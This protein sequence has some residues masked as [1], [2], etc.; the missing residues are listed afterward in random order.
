MTS[1]AS[2]FSQDDTSLVKNTYYCTDNCELSIIF[3]P[4]DADRTIGKN[5]NSTLSYTMLDGTSRAS[6]PI[7]WTRHQ[8][9][10]YENTYSMTNHSFTCNY[11]LALNGKEA[12]CTKTT[13]DPVNNSNIITTIFTSNEVLKVEGKTITYQE[14][15]TTEILVNKTEVTGSNT[16]VDNLRIYIDGAKYDG[17]DASSTTTLNLKKGTSHIL[18]VTGSMKNAND[19]VDIIPVVFGAALSKFALWNSTGILSVVYANTSGTTFPVNNS[20]QIL[21]GKQCWNAT[22]NSVIGCNSTMNSTWVKNWCEKYGFASD[23][24]GIDLRNSTSKMIPLQNF[25][26]A[27]Y[28]LNNACGSNCIDAWR[29]TNWT[30]SST[31]LNQ[32]IAFNATNVSRAKTWDTNTDEVLQ[33]EYEPS[34]VANGQLADLSGNGYSGTNTGAVYIQN[35]TCAKGSN[36]SA[37]GCY[38]FDTTTDKIDIGAAYTMPTGAW[39]VET[40]L[41][42][43]SDLTSGV[44]SI[45]FLKGATTQFAWYLFEN[46]IPGNEQID[47]GWR[48]SGAF[49]SVKGNWSDTLRGTW[50]HLVG[51]YDG[52]NPTGVSNYKLYINGVSIPVAEYDGI[53][54]S[55]TYSTIGSQNGGSSWIGYMDSFRIYNRTLSPAEVLG[56]YL[57]LNHNGNPSWNSTLPITGTTYFMNVTLISPA[58]NTLSTKASQTMYYN[59][60]S[61]DTVIACSLLINGSTNQTNST[62][63]SDVLSFFNISAFSDGSYLW[64]VNCTTNT[65]GSEVSANRT[66]IIDTVKPSCALVNRTPADINDTSTGL[67]NV[68]VNCTDANGINVT[69]TSGHFWA[70]ASRTVDGMM[71]PG[72]PNAWSIRPPYNNLTAI[73]SRF[74]AYPLF[75]AQGRNRGFWYESLGLNSTINNDTYSY[76]VDDGNY[77]YF[78]ITNTSSTTALINYTSIV[79]WTAFRQNAQLSYDSLVSEAKKNYSFTSTN[80]LLVKRY[81]LERIRGSVNYTVVVFADLGFTTLSPRL[82]RNYYCNSTY[83]VSGSARPVVSPN[84]ALVNTFTEAQI[85]NKSFLDRNSSYVRSTYSVTNG[86]LAGIVTTN[87]SYLYY[88]VSGPART[89]IMKYVNGPTVTNVSFAQTNSVWTSPDS[90]TT[91]TIAAWSADIIKTSVKKNDDE[92]QFGVYA[93]DL[94]GNCYFNATLFYDDITPTNHKISSPFIIA[95]NSS[96]APY[97]FTKNGIHSGVMGI[98]VNPAVDPDSVGNVTH[99]LTLR[100]TDGSWNYTIND[101]F[102]CPNDTAVW[103]YFNTSLVPMGDYRMNVSATS[104]DD[105]TDVRSYLTADNFTITCYTT[106]AGLCD[107]CR[108][109]ARNVS[110]TMS[111]SCV[112]VTGCT[113][114]VGDFLAESFNCSS[115]PLV[116]EIGHNRVN[117]SYHDPDLRN[118]TFDVWSKTNGGSWTDMT[119]IFALL[120]AAIIA[121]VSALLTGFVGFFVLCGMIVLLLSYELIAFS[122]PAAAL[123]LL[124]S[125]G[126]F[127]GL[128][129]RGEG[130]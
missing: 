2:A 126:L 42:M 24:T 85:T 128:F 108:Y 9:T 100:N 99:N 121:F 5:G 104:G 102:K 52:L 60:S 43:N 51:T 73:D 67:F 12:S 124:A 122:M 34:S 31:G 106:L 10:E 77:N 80:V 37:L 17:L 112:S 119:N 89:A 40:W 116:L 7:T 129:F 70:F 56:H 118:V 81:D 25:T 64:G 15:E 22:S 33:H 91:W 58:N 94:A 26:G 93:C 50:V 47:F 79:E 105:P 23:C 130:K 92:F 28:I 21:Y 107:G 41:R 74:P 19:A 82:V 44:R 18:K 8:W 109:Q 59:V 68:L 75:R 87:E 76:A 46:G 72:V 127:L 11:D 39:T 95:Y 32:M 114:Q 14:L 1:I 78:N 98:L 45:A 63:I 48:N 115:F 35:A 71:T 4:Q 38:E 84:C 16:K 61:N 83:N 86:L 66:I 97:D 125:I 57:Q 111:S 30:Q 101:S 96:T 29:V 69:K 36:Y 13:I 27:S 55:G 6:R 120:L 54:G 113:V 3:T 117:V 20:E 65:G 123:C 49:G 88:D 53:G 103:V 62:V 90:G 110:F